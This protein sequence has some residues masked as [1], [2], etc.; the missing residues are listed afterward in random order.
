MGSVGVHVHHELAHLH[1][2]GE[3]VEVL[4]SLEWF[5]ALLASAD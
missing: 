1:E 4:C 3:D 2:D 5:E